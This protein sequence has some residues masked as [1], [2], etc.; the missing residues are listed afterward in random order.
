MVPYAVVLF[1]E[2]VAVY[3][4]DNNDDDDDDDEEGCFLFFIVELLLPPMSV[5][6]LIGKKSVESNNIEKGRRWSCVLQVEKR[7]KKK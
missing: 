4:S 2:N 5:E 7:R 6:L 1:S 3:S